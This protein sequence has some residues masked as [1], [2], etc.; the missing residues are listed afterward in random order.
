MKDHLR[1]GG[2]WT[3]ARYNAFIKS[4][5]R[6]AS[7]KWPPKF[8]VKKRAWVE[9]GK[10]RCSGYEQ[11]PHIVPAKEIVIDHIDPVICPEK[12]FVSWDDTIERMF[13]EESGLQ[14][15]CKD[16]HKR[17]TIYERTIRN[18]AKR[19]GSPSGD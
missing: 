11:P 13:C 10:Y 5:L 7:N 6:T 12:G 9:R 15:L 8:T 19:N 4:A 18:T 2:Q 17:K 3:E 1:N 16:C 14:A